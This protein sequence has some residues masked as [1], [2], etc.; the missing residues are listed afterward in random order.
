MTPEAL[1]QLAKDAINAST[2][3]EGMSDE[4]WEKAK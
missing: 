3:P 4:E 1:D 2:K